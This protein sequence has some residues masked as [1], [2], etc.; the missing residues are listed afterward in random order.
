MRFN[1]VHPVTL[2]ALEHSYNPTPNFKWL[3]A[4][5]FTTCL[6]CPQLE[7]VFSSRHQHAYMQSIV[8]HPICRRNILIIFPISYLPID[9]SVVRIFKLD[10]PDRWRWTTETQ[11]RPLD[12]NARTT[13]MTRFDVK[14]FF[15]YSQKVSFYFFFNRKVNTVIFIDGGSALSR[16]QNDNTAWF[17]WFDN[18]FP[19]LRRFRS[20]PY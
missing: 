13:A 9:R 14:V 5:R 16:S 20:N 1:I 19:L 15:V 17:E 12:S 4:K 7:H 3:A 10:D 6:V 2:F 11:E 8:M 18:L